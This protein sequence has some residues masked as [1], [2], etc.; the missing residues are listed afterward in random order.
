M[1]SKAIL[2]AMLLFLPLVSPATTGNPPPVETDWEL[3]RDEDGIRSYTGVIPGE[4]ILAFKGEAMLES[5]P[6]TVLGV[7][8]DCGRVGEWIPRMRDSKVVRWIA[9]PHEYVQYT[10]FEAP[11]PV[12]DRIFLTRVELRVDSESLRTE[13]RYLNSDE[14]IL[15]DY[16]ISE[17]DVIRGSAAGSYYIVEPVDSGKRTRLTAVSIADPRGSIPEWVINWV[18]TSM[19]HNSMSRLREQLK[20]PDLVDLPMATRLFPIRR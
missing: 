14:A 11:W 17:D 18:G 10:R 8:L 13:I 16:S 7:L 19:S 1:K 5:D 3:V 9:E 15:A 20:R 6:V 12:T 4:P 2:T